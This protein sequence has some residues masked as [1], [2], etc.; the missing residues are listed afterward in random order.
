MYWLT[1]APVEVKGNI[2]GRDLASGLREH[3]ISKA[4]Q[5]G[6]RWRRVGDV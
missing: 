3:K 2:S 4:V 1:A 5:C 6:V